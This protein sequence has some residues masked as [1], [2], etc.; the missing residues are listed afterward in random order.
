MARRAVGERVTVRC[1]DLDRSFDGRVVLIR[2]RRGV[3]A[4]ERS[5]ALGAGTARLRDQSRHRQPRGPSQGGG[6]RWTWN[7]RPVLSIRVDDLRKSFAGRPALDGLAAEFAP[8]TLHGLIGPDGAGENHLPAA[9]RGAAPAH[10]RSGLFTPGTVV[11]CPSRTSAPAWPTCPRPRA[12]TPTFPSGNTWISS[13][14]C[15]RCPPGTIAPAAIVC[16]V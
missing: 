12:S 2:K 11:P 1:P 16:W 9:A 6:C 3:H 13:A 5:N 14:T 4:Q 7:G 8:G 15:T 10:E